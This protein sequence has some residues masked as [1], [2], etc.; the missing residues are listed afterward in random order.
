MSCPLQALI[1]SCEAP[2]SLSREPNVRLIAL[3]DNEEVSG[4][5]AVTCSS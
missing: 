5:G 4:G 1:S 3:Y 2:G